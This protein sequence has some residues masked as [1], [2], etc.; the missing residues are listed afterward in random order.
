VVTPILACGLR[1]EIGTELGRSELNRYFRTGWG[2]VSVKTALWRLK[3]GWIV[4]LWN[5]SKTALRFPLVAAISKINAVPG[6]NRKP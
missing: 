1:V 5:H 3:N 4:R 6:R 2:K